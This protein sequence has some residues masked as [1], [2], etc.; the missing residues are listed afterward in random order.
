VKLSQRIA[1]IPVLRAGLGMVEAMQ[2][3]LPQVN[4]C[5]TCYEIN[6]N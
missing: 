1:L 5:S 4:I 2:D 3:L 6:I